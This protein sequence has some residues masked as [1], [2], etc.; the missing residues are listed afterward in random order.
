MTRLLSPLPTV[1]VGANNA[2]S[3]IAGAVGIALPDARLQLLGTPAGGDPTYWSPL[4]LYYNGTGQTITE[5]AWAMAFRYVGQAF[6]FIVRGNGGKYR[7]AAN[8]LFASDLGQTIPGDGG[9]HR[10]LVDFGSVGTWDVVVQFSG[11]AFVSG[12]SIGPSDTLAA[13]GLSIGPRVC[14]VGDSFTAG[15]GAGSNITTWHMR[16]AEALGWWNVAASAEGG[17]GYAK[18]TAGNAYCYID[19]VAK[20]IAAFPP[21]IVIV[22]GGVNDAVSGYASSVGAAALALYSTL[23]GIA[24]R[25][26]ALTPFQPTVTAGWGLAPVRLAI[27]NAAASTGIQCIDVMGPA[28]WVTGTGYVAH[29]NG[30]GSSDAYTS[31]DGTHPSQAGHDYLGQRL[32]WAISPPSTGLRGGW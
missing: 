23:K 20:D 28:P 14:V 26:V 17:T 32:A 5:N 9:P 16:M 1:T 27:Q 7:V 11:E 12:V 24:P 6:E 4:H 30:T 31:S 15:T 8:G 10:V 2:A 18:P 3:A 13:Y 21:D 22:T 25:V 29:E 19:R